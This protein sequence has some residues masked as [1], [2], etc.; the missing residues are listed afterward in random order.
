M[1]DAMARHSSGILSMESFRRVIGDVRPA[2]QVAAREP[3]SG[4][5]PLAA[6]FGHFPSFDEI[7]EYMV[8]EAMKMA[9][10]NQSI[11]A[12]ILGIG[13]QTLNKRLKIKE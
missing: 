4:E 8:N 3:S 10:G 5:S 6:M 7:E 11:A 12:N 2:T 1:F 9:K 13:R